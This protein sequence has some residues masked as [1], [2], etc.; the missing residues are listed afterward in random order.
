MRLDKFLFEKGIIES[1]NKA[2]F[3]ITNGEIFV[4]GKSVTKNSF[5]VSETDTIEWKQKENFVSKGGFKL[6]KAFNDF[7]ITVN[8]LIACDV[9]ASTGGF[10]DVLLKNGAK[11]VYAVDVSDGLLHDSLKNDPR[12]FPLIK[13]VKDLKKEDFDEEI[14]FITADLSFISETVTLPVLKSILKP[15]GEMIILIKPQFEMQEKRRFKNGIVNDEKA[16]RSAVINVVDHAEKMGFTLKSITNA[17][18]IDGK[19]REYLAYF[20]NGFYER[21]DLNTFKF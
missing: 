20:K 15:D 21:F 7:G 11:K 9:G 18:K 16:I 17:P 10:T 5:D 8:G 3:A 12:V 13:N 2:S 14:D 19:N 6:N 1:R 4:N